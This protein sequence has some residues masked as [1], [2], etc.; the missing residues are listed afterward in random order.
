MIWWSRRSSISPKDPGH[1]HTK[2]NHVVSQ[3]LM[4][5]FNSTVLS[6]EEIANGFTS[7]DDILTPEEVHAA[8]P[9]TM[10]V[11]ASWNHAPDAQRYR[12]VIPTLPM[13]YDAQEASRRVL[14]RLLELA[15]PG[16]QDRRGPGK[17]NPVSLMYLPCLRPEMFLPIVFAGADFD[18]CDVVRTCPPDIIDEV[19]RKSPLDR[20]REKKQ[21]RSSQR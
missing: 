12:V 8:L 19:I 21:H 14:V 7:E 20:T 17:L 3:G 16:R 2:K 13:T 4:L 9:Y 18:H 6:N 5:D 1:G 10:L 11:Y 15:Y